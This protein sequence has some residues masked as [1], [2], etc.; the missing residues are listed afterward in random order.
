MP[1]FVLRRLT[2]LWE[3]L[4]AFGRLWVHIPDVPPTTGPP[5]GHPE[6]LC[7][8]LPPTDRERALWDDLT[9]GSP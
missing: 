9:G 5:P 7:P 4:I 3:A 1:L 2:E 6:R 8:E